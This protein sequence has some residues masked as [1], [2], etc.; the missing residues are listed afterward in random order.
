MELKEEPLTQPLTKEELLLW[1]MVPVKPGL[2]AP[3]QEVNSVNPGCMVS[4]RE[5]SMRRE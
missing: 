1:G 3:T 4:N 5:S 2:A